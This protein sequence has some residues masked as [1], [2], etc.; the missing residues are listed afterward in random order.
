MP[1][2]SSREVRPGLG[3]RCPGGPQEAA[4]HSREGD[5][6]VPLLSQVTAPLPPAQSSAVGG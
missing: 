2:G 1:G 5:K 4:S 6:A 3:W